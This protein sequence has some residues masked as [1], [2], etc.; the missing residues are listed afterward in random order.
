M[1]WRNLHQVKEKC[2]VI[3][4]KKDAKKEK[5]LGAQRSSNQWKVTIEIMKLLA[6]TLGNMVES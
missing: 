6:K 2:S 5:K 3:V 4:L 1:G